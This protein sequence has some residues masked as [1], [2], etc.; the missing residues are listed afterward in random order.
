MII[1]DL[2]LIDATLFYVIVMVFILI[3][4]DKRRVKK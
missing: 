2:L 1:Q 4:Y 3:E